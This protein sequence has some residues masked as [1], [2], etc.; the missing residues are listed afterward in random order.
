MSI[1]VIGNGMAGSRFVTE[2]R[3]RDRETPLTVFGAERQQPYN[4]VLLSNV[5]AGVAGPDQIGLVDPAWYGRNDVDARLG[6]EV[7]RIDRA[8]RRVHASDG[9]VTPYETLVIATGSTSFVPPIPG[10]ED[11]LPPGAVAFRTLDD[12]SAILDAAASARTAVVVGGGLLG[13]EAARGLAGRGLEVTV[14]HLAGHLMERQ[15]D[16]GAGKVLARTLGRLGIRAL[17]DANVT[18]LRMGAR[19]GAPGAGTA[20]GGTRVTGVELASGDVVEGDLVVMACGVKPE[21]GLARAAGLEID[22]GVVVDETLTSVTDPAVRAIGECSQYGD[23]V[24]GLVAPAWEQATVLADVLTGADAGARFTGAR[25]ITRLKAASVELAAM[26]ETHHGD[27]DPDV[28]IMQFADASRGTY[29]KVVIRN[30][31]VIGAIL[32]GETSTAG[33]LTQLYDRAAPLPAD[34]L[35]LFFPGTGGAQAADSP[36]RMPDAATVCHCNNVSKGQI[37][38]CWEKG[39]RSAI[40]VAAETRAST[41]CGGCRDALEGIVAWLDEQESAPVG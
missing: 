17:L 38:A 9:S 7:V 36:V 40:E 21:V 35:S 15:L 2:V 37:R 27:D 41:G 26:G 33:T 4:R 19:A 10:T 29:K 24:Y 6:V 30:D 32:L 3:A 39:A 13:I 22:R 14:V 8:A 5:L 34:R 11:G 20:A 18:G 31:R 28:E 23:V 1:V 12:C 25:Q 16:P